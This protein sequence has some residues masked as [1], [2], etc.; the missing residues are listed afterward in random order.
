MRASFKK[1]V[2]A[3]IAAYSRFSDA[4]SFRAGLVRANLISQDIWAQA[5]AAGK[6][7]DATPALNMLM[8]PALNEMIDLTTTRAAMSLMHPPLA[9]RYMLI[10]LALVAALLGGIGLGKARQQRL[11]YEVAFASFMTLTIFITLDLEY[12]RTGL[13]RVDNFETAIVNFS[14]GN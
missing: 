1:Y 5:V 4:D 14:R 3:R 12:P 2:D 13:I 7:P 9:I 6:R 11:V 8:L 10:A